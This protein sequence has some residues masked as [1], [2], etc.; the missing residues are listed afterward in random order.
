[1]QLEEVY[2]VEITKLVKYADQK[3]TST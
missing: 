2:A 1:M 3:G